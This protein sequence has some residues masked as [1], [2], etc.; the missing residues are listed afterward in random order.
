VS[1]GRSRQLGELHEG[2]D[3][4][5]GAG[6]D[7]PVACTPARE[8]GADAYEEEDAGEEHRGPDVVV[9]GLAAD[10]PAANSSCAFLSSSL[11]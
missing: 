9:G 7:E 10:T 3:E 8:V 1:G 5:R 11:A 2:D 4:H 6:R